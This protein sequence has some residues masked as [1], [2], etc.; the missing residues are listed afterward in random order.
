[1][2]F[3]LIGND[4]LKISCENLVGS[5]RFPHAILLEGAAGIGRHT[6]ARFL[7]A[8]ALCTE[9]DVPCDTCRSC[10]LLSVGTHP[11]FVCVAPESGKKSIS[12]DQIR[13]LRQQVFVKAHIA[14]R[15]VFWVDGA[16]RMNEQAQNALLKILEEPPAGV[17]IMLIASSRM[18]LLDT[19]VSRCVILSPG[20][21]KTE[22][23]VDYIREKHPA[24]PAEIE[25]ALRQADGRI[26]RALELLDGK[27]GDPASEAAVRFLEL[28]DE[29]GEW[30]LLR[31]LKPF[32]KDRAGTDALFAALKIETA[33]ALRKNR[34]MLT[35]ARLLNRF[36]ERICTYETY[37]KTN[38]K[39]A[40][41]F[42]T[43]VCD[44]V[45]LKNE[46]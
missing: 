34:D 44:T 16:E 38:A 36:Y 13:E 29:G 10:H 24:Q 33:R 8:A 3:P 42:S 45:R 40:L 18:A 23:S 12:V 37:L 6:L 19:I 35:K 14:E 21:P 20:I 2:K 27:K 9:R 30:E 7:T 41:L 25:K 28:L 43:L 26:G 46:I 31:L 17:I 15:R 32:E 5:G 1:M 22:Q 11:D 39:L 4:R